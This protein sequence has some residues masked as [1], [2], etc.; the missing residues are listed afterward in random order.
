MARLN[1]TTQATPVWGDLA[2]YIEDDN[3]VSA[4]TL[5]QGRA[6]ILP[7][8]LHHTTRGQQMIG[9]WPTAIQDDEPNFAIYTL[10]NELRVR[11]GAVTAGDEIAYSAATDYPIAVV[12]A[13]GDIGSPYYKAFSK[14]GDWWYLDWI[15]RASDASNY[16]GLSN[17]DSVGYLQIDKPLELRDRRASTFGCL[18]EVAAPVIGTGSIDD[19]VE[20]EMA[21]YDFYMQLDVD[22]L[23]V[24]GNIKFVYRYSDS[25]N[26]L[27]F[28]VNSS[29]DVIF[30]ERFE[31][32]DYDLDTSTGTIAAGQTLR[33]I[34]NHYNAKVWADDTLIQDWTDTNDNENQLTGWGLV[35]LGADGEISNLF[36]DAYAQ[37]IETGLGADLIVNGVFAADTDW[38][39]GAN[40]TIAAGVASHTGGNDD[41][42]AT[43]DPLT[44]GK[45]YKAQFTVSNYV[46]G[47]LSAV[48]GDVGGNFYAA[49]FIFD[50]GT[51]I[52]YELALV[53]GAF[54]LDS[55]GF[56]GD[57]DNVIVQEVLFANNEIANILD[58][59]LS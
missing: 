22:T 21:P 13:A 53:D 28:L 35:D 1:F 58:S 45:I 6:W 12:W 14:R 3:N 42:E 40:W 49:G 25:A 23:P 44:A 47:T 29:G 17:Y 19:G 4:F 16:I 50:N 9:F 15:H 31:D 52:G 24:T 11:A 43:V 48:V 57:V 33:I 27:Y 55:Q 51:S 41:I 38:T 10:A 26:Y 5:R 39:K 34:N 46:T 18:V 8:I 36:V 37:R 54:K 7:T 2:G 56:Q 20:A 59:M 32:E 30:G